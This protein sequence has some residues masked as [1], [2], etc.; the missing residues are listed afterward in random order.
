[1]MTWHALPSS[2]VSSVAERASA[3]ASARGGGAAVAG[4]GEA[5]HSLCGCA[6]PAFFRMCASQLRWV[7]HTGIRSRR[8]ARRNFAVV[9]KRAALDEPRRSVL[10][11]VASARREEPFFS[12]S[13]VGGGRRTDRPSP[14][15]TARRTTRVCACATPPSPA[16]EGVAAQSRRGDTRRRRPTPPCRRWGD[17]A[18]S[19]SLL[20]RRRGSSLLRIWNGIGLSQ[21]PR[22]RERVRRLVPAAELGDPHAVRKRGTTIPD[23]AL[24]SHRRW[25]VFW[26]N[27]KGTTTRKR[28]CKMQPKAMVRK[29][30]RT[31]WRP[32]ALEP[33]EQRRVRLALGRVG[34]A[35][36]LAQPLLVL[37]VLER[38]ARLHVQ[39]STGGRRRF[40]GSI[41]VRD[42]SAR[43][44]IRRRCGGS[45]Y[46]HQPER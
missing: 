43:R 27:R 24:T 39:V 41:R 32:V 19:R 11:S 16:R 18:G 21:K 3:R 17:A 33:L 34:A 9:V 28:G 7:R 14:T 13:F 12:F 30:R 26:R 23:R 22:E 4:G 36:H 38:A 42:A 45:V 40:G 25:A 46:T 15:P 8:A 6:T 35:A 37:L 29:R 5:R 20:D 1:M 31:R 2:S 44:A 10:S